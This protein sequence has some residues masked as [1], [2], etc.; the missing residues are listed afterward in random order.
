MSRRDPLYFQ[1]KIH[2]YLNLVDPM[3]KIAVG[4][5]RCSTDMQEDSPRQQQE[6]IQKFADA[7]GYN[8][9]EWYIDFGIS[10]TSFEKRPAFM[11]MLL[12]AEKKLFQFEYIICWDEARWGR[13]SNPRDNAGWKWHFSRL[14]IEIILVQTNSITGNRFTDGVIEFVESAQAS[15]YSRNLSRSTLRG[16]IDNAKRGFSC[17]G[18][19][20]YGYARVAVGKTG[21]TKPRVLKIGEHINYQVEKSRLDLGDPFEVEVVQR[22]FEL[23]VKGLGYVRICDVLNADKIPPPKRGRWKNRDQKWSQGTVMTIL[24]NPSYYGCRVY[25][26]HPQSHL[27][28]PQKELWWNKKEDWV[29]TENAHPAIVSKEIY[30]LANK[31]RKEYTRKNRHFYESPYLLSGLIRCS[32]CGFNFQ[33]QT[34]TKEK[35]KYYFDG[36]YGNKGKSVCTSYRIKKEDIESFVI[37]AIRSKILTSDLPNRIEETLSKKLRETSTDRLKGIEQFE[38]SLTETKLK[39][40]RLLTAVENGVDYDVTIERLKEAQAE[41]KQIENRIEEIKSANLTRQD[42]VTARERVET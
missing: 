25:N 15:E 13:G 41:K 38:R 22:I 32:H 12:A 21:E 34:L 24:G 1:D 40:D 28:G 14:R 23:K 39:I 36:G 30:E 35:L 29:V 4:Y 16:S 42:I 20:P 37:R 8:I 26:R 10:G 5:V 19:A 2:Y 7:Q 33:G 11:R 6:S 17:G 9:V 18:S 31:N 27:S 3:K